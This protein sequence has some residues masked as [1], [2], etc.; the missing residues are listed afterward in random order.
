MKERTS[1]NG[2]K[3]VRKTSIIIQY[4]KKKRVDFLNKQ[5]EKKR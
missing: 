3:R 1:L 2:F 5:R 4:K